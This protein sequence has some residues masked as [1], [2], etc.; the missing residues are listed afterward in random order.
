MARQI[1][2][3]SHMGGIDVIGFDTL[4]LPELSPLPTNLVRVVQM[5]YISRMK[6]K[7]SITLSEDVWL[8]M[9]RMATRYRNRSALIETAL[10]EFLVRLERAEQDQRDL[11]ILNRNAERLNQEAADVLEYQGEL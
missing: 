3:G 6:I 8:A 9:E 1:G 4:E 5:E 11:E 2:I 10:R 7:T